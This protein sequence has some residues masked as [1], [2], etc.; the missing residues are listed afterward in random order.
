VVKIH[1]Q[2]RGAIHGAG[3]IGHSCPQGAELKCN[4][5]YG[6]LGSQVGGGRRR[7]VEVRGRPCISRPQQSLLAHKLKG[8]SST[9]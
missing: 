6:G 3:N 7:R 5:N 9:L 4:L 2:R 8:S 1:V